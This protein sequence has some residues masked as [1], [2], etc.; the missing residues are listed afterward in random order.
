M[1]HFICSCGNTL[2]FENT[3]C[4]QCGLDVGYDPV[5]AR[6]VALAPQDGVVRCRNGQDYG[7][8][9]WLA[10]GNGEVFCKS[11]RLN[12]TV[13]DLGFPGNRDAWKRVESAKRRVLYTLFQLGIDPPRWIDDAGRG[14]AF[15]I[16][17]PVDSTPVLTGYANGVITLNLNEADSAERERRRNQLAEPYRTLVGHF[18]HESAHYVWQQFFGWKAEGDVALQAFRELFGDERADY[19]AALQH[20]YSYGAPPGWETEFI[21]GYATAHPHEDWAE[22][23]A[24]Y[25][26]V[27]DG[28]ETAADFGLN[29]KAVPIPF[30]RFPPEAADLPLGLSLEAG[31]KK[32]F[33]EVLHSWAKLSPALNEVAASIGQDTLYPFIF[34]LKV[35]RKLCFIHWM[36][37]GWKQ[38]NGTM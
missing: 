12:R 18:R 28:T 27:T 24:H 9:N 13:P 1:R 10:V 3:T 30:T 32:R 35:V 15:D 2:F 19:A 4:L 26:H 17:A 33:M 21:S 22:C 23:W 6:M 7:A 20:Y 25:L 11:C 5:G 14:L 29:S 37:L 31:E 16:L 36:V 38:V 8:C 34:S